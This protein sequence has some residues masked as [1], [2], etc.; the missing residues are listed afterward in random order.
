[1]PTGPSYKA[2]GN[3][4]TSV[5]LQP[6]WTVATDGF[7]LFNGKC[8][9]KVNRDQALAGIS[10]FARGAAHPVSPFSGY[11]A[12]HKIDATYDKLGIATVT[13]DYVGINNTVGESAVDYTNPNVSGSDSLTGENITA[14]PKFFISGGIAGVPGATTYTESDLGPLVQVLNVTTGKPVIVK[15]WEGN[16]GACFETADG[17]KF[18]GFV[19]PAYPKL[20]GKTQYL[21]PT[22]AFSGIIY[23]KSTSSKPALL[24]A[25]VG[26]TSATQYFAAVK[27]L[28]DYIGTTFQSADSDHDD[29]LMLSQ[30]NFEDYGTIFKCTYEIRYNR[31]GYTREVYDNGAS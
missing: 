14:H 15:S 3:D 13:A 26:K 4:L 16:N 2:Q 11:M 29:C 10:S 24:R 18:I 25:A 5:I 17:G 30:V 12:V 22:T 23:F 7:G 20:Y 28:P 1:M 8:T 31:Y 27:L 19:D 9:F 6:N 21:A